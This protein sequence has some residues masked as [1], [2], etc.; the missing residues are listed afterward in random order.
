MLQINKEQQ[1]AITFRD[2]TLLLIAGPG[3][4]KTFVL[5]NRI[6]ALIDS[7]IDSSHI[8]VIT[9]TKAAASEMQSRFERL[10]TKENAVSFGTFHSIFYSI[11]KHHKKYSNVV[12]ITDK[13]K[14]NIIKRTFEIVN[15]PDAKENLD[16]L[17][18]TLGLISACKNNGNQPNAFTQNK[19][20][21][22]TFTSI[23]NTYNDLLLEFNKI[24]FDD[25]INLCLGLLA[26]EPGYLKRWQDKYSYILID[27]F[28]DISSNQYELV[29]LLA[30]P[31]NNIFAVGDD[32]QS[33]YRFRGARVEI[34][35]R[36]QE[37]FK[38]SE[39]KYLSVNY[40]CESEIVTVANQVISENT[41]RFAK[42]IMANKSGG[43]SVVDIKGFSSPIK[44]NEYIIKLL[45]GCSN[46]ELNGYA[47]LTRNNRYGSKY[48]ALL[49]SNNILV[50]YK[51][52]TIPFSASY[53]KD[54]CAYIEYAEGNH[55]RE[56]FLR[57]MN[58]PLRYI[59][60]D[61]IP[62]FVNEQKLID[63]YESDSFMQKRIKLMFEQ[64]ARIHNMSIFLAINYIRKVIGYD[65][66]MKSGLS[67]E[68]YKRYT[69]E[70]EEFTSICREC[71]S[72]LEIQEKLKMIQ[73]SEAES[74]LSKG[75]HIYTYHSSKG[76]E[77]SRVIL[78]D[79]NDGIIPTK[80]AH[81]NED[82][83]EER[84]ML[85][86]A[87]T[88]AQDNLHILYRTDENNKPSRFIGK[89]L[90]DKT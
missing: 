35:H 38:D 83:E 55:S 26:N 85:Y 58:K 39:T 61:Y 15:L 30:S 79:V 57:I 14:L 84:R 18:S 10:M 5:T 9:F 13:E 20:D 59:K 56:V 11:L 33:I 64:L 7:G 36:L 6:K 48:A 50:D 37:D 45:Q 41:L 71:K 3:S 53:I 47:I 76:L 65:E 28:Q 34:M 16:E 89:I 51:E 4:G 75:V 29:K 43:C 77:F 54:I 8:L 24:D 68:L 73:S 74:S 81:T 25:M 60:R 19:Y 72:Y 87:M 63:A 69:E 17:L 42:N 70:I 86:V 40:R 22:A 67:A 46:E 44:Q 12:P 78:P 2:G 21:S 49:R 62:S 82:I 66:Y 52:K 88:R 32:D 27:E 31:E 80:S 1:D 23:F 90:N